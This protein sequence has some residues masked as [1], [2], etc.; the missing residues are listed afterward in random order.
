MSNNIAAI[1]GLDD[2]DSM[3]GDE[4]AEVLGF[5]KPEKETKAQVEREETDFLMAEIRSRLLTAGELP[6]DKMAT[7]IGAFGS[8]ASLAMGEIG[9]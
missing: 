9:E 8:E 5:E 4:M 2:M 3:S 1:C 7:L 6:L